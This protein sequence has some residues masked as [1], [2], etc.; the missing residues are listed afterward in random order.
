M[1]THPEHRIYNP[2]YNTH[3]IRAEHVQK[4]AVTSPCVSIHYYYYCCY[5][6]PRGYSS[7]GLSHIWQSTEAVLQARAALVH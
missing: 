2:Y 7:P 6:Y 1:A 3:K 4:E 5:C